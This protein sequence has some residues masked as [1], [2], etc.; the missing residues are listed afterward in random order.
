GSEATVRGLQAERPIDLID[1]HYLYP[2]GYAA[3]LLAERLNVPVVITAR[4][5]DMNLFS[6]MP[7]IRRLIPSAVRRRDGGICVSGALTRRMVEVGIAADKIAVIRNGVD[8]EIFYPRNQM[9]MR[10]KLGLDSESRVIVA[11]GA[12]VPLK[13][14]DRL[15]DAMALVRDV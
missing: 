13:G 10:R 14:V 7:L 9:E 3:G 12:L 4:G 15:I 1:A 11:A 2:D 8:R 6:R 5:T